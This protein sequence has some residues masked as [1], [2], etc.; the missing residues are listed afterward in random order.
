MIKYKELILINQNT[1]S[2]PYGRWNRQSTRVLLQ[3]S[4]IELL[5]SVHSRAH[6]KLVKGLALCLTWPRDTSEKRPLLYCEQTAAEEKKPPPLSY[7]SFCLVPT[8]STSPLPLASS[9]TITGSDPITKGG[10]HVKL[11]QPSW[12]IIC[13]CSG[14]KLYS[15]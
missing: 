7:R 13:V 10:L 15:D 2:F 12:P 9:F 5:M 14:V 3:L 8:N 4:S 1:L 11:G 6:N